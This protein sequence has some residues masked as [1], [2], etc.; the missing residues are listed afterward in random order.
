MQ[1]VKKLLCNV[2]VAVCLSG[3]GAAM[4]AAAQQTLVHNGVER[5]YTVRAP[6][7]L[8]PGARW[9]LVLVL[10]GGGGSA[11]H[12][13]AMTGFT[14]KA[15][16]EGF[17]VVYP[18]GS[19]RFKGRLL[20]WNAGHCC[21][22]AMQMKVDDVAF[23]N[24][25]ID[26]LSQDYP[27]DPQRIYV[28]GMSNGGMMAHRVGIELPHRFA[29]IAPVVAT[30]FGDEP[31][32]TQP[33]SALMLN[34]ELDQSVP[35][36]G[37]APGGRFPDAWDGTLAQPAL[38]QA[39]FWA[40]A[41]ACVGTPDVLD[42]GIFVLTQYR[43]PAGKAVAAYLIK[44]NGHAWPGGRAGSRRADRPSTSLDGTDLIWEFFKAHAK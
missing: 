26:Q 36:Q 15:K 38:A 10:H 40:K 25:L 29:A 4:T 11:A 31:L 32:P 5:G 16:Q 44:D 24:A 14:E 41:N 27:I 33:V 30:L 28:T 9:P 23:I 12:A 8:G 42:R 17:M 21:G 43:C 6:S 37:G 19:G 20:T 34:G 18:E 39:T 22:H 7:G 2:M 3:P 13:E 1:N 35:Y